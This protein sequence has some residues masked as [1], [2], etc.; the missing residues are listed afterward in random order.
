[1]SNFY[2]RLVELRKERSLTQK[3]LAQAIGAN[4][5]GIRFYEA[6]AKQPTMDSLIKLADFF[7]VSLDYLVGRSDDARPF[8]NG[9]S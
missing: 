5:R 7:N 9:A 8:R 2:S 3:Q 1:M 4:E 6:G